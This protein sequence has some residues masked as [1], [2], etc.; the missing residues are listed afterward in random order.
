MIDHGHVTVTGVTSTSVCAKPTIV[1]K[2]KVEDMRGMDYLSNGDLVVV[3]DKC[4]NIYDKH[5][6]EMLH[7]LSNV[8]KSDEG[9]FRDV[10][11]DN[12]RHRVI[13]LEISNQNRPGYLHVY[14]SVD[15]TWEYKRVLVC[16]KGNYVALNKRGDFSIGGDDS[17]LSKYNTDGRRSWC[18]P[19][20]D[21]ANGLFV[22]CDDLILVSLD[23][24]VTFYQQN[25]NILK[26][27]APNRIDI[28]PHGIWVNDFG[29]IFICDEKSESVLIYDK[30]KDCSQTLIDMESRPV[31][32]TL[33]SERKLATSTN[34]DDSCDSWL[35]VY[36]FD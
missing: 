29:Q 24:D 35:Y 18:V 13:I 30:Y 19:M 34:T 8:C 1:W 31:C 25:G 11:V 36:N 6:S 20:T 27:I 2:R 33:L 10:Y 14:T 3:T 23:S 12:R 4:V 22:D 28:S 26:V 17:K 7:Y 21:R 9:N 15:N 16:R 32:I 5:G